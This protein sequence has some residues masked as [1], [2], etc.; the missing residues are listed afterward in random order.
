MI[1]SDDGLLT[2]EIPV[3]AMAEPVDITATAIAS[4]DLPPELK[5]LAPLGA[6][7]LEPDGLVFDQPDPG[8]DV[9]QQQHVENRMRQGGSTCLAAM[10][11]QRATTS[12]T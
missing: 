9:G 12:A 6:Y 5:E 1:T 11:G 2:I 10:P 3:G 4:A 7:A 8:T